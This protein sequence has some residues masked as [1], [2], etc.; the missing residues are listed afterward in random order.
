MPILCFENLHPILLDVKLSTQHTKVFCVPQ[1]TINKK[2]FNQLNNNCCINV[3]Y[4]KLEAIG[5]APAQLLSSQ[6]RDHN[7]PPSNFSIC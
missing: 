6:P 4:D 7:K 5:H 1:L 2:G 3:T